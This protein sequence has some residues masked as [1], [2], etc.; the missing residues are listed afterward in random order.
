MRELPLAGLLIGSSTERE[1]EGGPVS[2]YLCVS[3]MH[4]SLACGVMAPAA[5]GQ[6]CTYCIV[7]N[8]G[9]FDANALKQHH[10]AQVCAS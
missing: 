7:V 1:R 9:M 8:G 4:V 5:E 2:T 3:T 6:H 10:S